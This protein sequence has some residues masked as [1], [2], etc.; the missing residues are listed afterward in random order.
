MMC[1]HDVVPCA[2]PPVARRRWFAAL[3][4]CTALVVTSC[5]GGGGTR[6][7]PALEA[8]SS[9]AVAPGVTQFSVPDGGPVTWGLSERGASTEGAAPVYPLAVAQNGR[10]LVDQTGK[11]WRVQADAAWLMSAVA[12]PEQVDDYLTTRKAQGF[13]SFYLMAMVHPGA[14]ETAPN[15]PNNLEGDPPFATPDDFSTAG[16]SPESSRYWQGV[17]SIIAKAA[18]K[19]MV[20]MLAYTYL[21]YEG[22]DQGW[23]QDVLAQRDQQVLYD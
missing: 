22:G 15:A 10:Y 12:T 2:R 21:G 13:N 18:D 3:A 11:P 4:L 9:S 7:A 8:A 6:R 5:A 20:V 1:V 16:A 19:G 14:S 17:D 23:Y